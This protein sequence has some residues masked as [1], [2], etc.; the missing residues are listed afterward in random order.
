M[1]RIFQT[2]NEF[3][4]W[5]HIH[6]FCHTRLIG[7]EGVK[8]LQHH[9]VRIIMAHMNITKRRAYSNSLFYPHKYFCGSEITVAH[10]STAVMHVESKQYFIILH[11]EKIWFTTNNGRSQCFWWYF[12][13]VGM[14]FIL[15]LSII[16]GVSKFIVLLSEKPAEE[17]PVHLMIET[18]PLYEILCL[19][20]F[21]T[22]DC[23]QNSSHI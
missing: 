19:E 5:L 8:N 17:E 15:H 14:T 2:N 7:K 22:L 20:Y 12:V 16:W 10:V 9:A 21:K 23:V 1:C 3:Y 13:A 11:Q 18:D 6:C 4:V